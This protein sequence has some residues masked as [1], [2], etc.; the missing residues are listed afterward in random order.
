VD[1]IQRDVVIAAPPEVVWEVITEPEHVTQ[2]FADAEFEPKPGANGRIAAY[3][4][5]I[6][7]V[8]RPRRFSFT[9]DSSLLVEFTLAEEEGGTRLRVEESGFENRDKRTDHEGGWA[10]FLGRLREY[11]E[12]R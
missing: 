3:E 9:W 4:I 2:W 12:A 7:D 5:R 8:D 1:R 11:A 10:K 6:E